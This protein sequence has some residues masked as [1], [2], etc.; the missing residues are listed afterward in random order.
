[1]KQWEKMKAELEKIL[2]ELAAELSEAVRKHHDD[3]DGV[4]REFE[5]KIDVE[6]A[7]V[8]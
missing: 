8:H 4:L 3:V 7:T 2:E 1:M 5:E 6:T